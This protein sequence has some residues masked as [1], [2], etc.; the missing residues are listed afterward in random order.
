MDQIRV[1]GDLAK[2]VVR[3]QKMVHPEKQSLEVAKAVFAIRTK[4]SSEYMK[5]HKYDLLYDPNADEKIKM[6]EDEAEKIFRDELK[7][8]APTTSAFTPEAKGETKPSKA[9][10]VTVRAIQAAKTPRDFYRLA[11]QPEGVF[12]LEEQA[13]LADALVLKARELKIPLK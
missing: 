7:V 8:T 12:S 11:Q 6:I 3:L 13:Q 4:A 10:W 5:L 2:E 1:R 9:L